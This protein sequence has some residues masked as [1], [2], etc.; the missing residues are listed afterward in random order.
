MVYIAHVEQYIWL[1]VGEYSSYVKGS[2]FLFIPCPLKSLLRFVFSIFLLVWWSYLKFPF[3]FIFIFTFIFTSL[4]FVFSLY[5]LVLTEQL[6]I[7]FHFHFH[8][9]IFNT[10]NFTLSSFIL[11]FHIFQIC[12]FTS[13]SCDDG[14]TWNWNSLSLSHLWYL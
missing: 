13:S 8:F 14:S 9:H 4:R 5:F 1:M 10:C 6:E 3:T 11:H 7:H 12:I 2:S